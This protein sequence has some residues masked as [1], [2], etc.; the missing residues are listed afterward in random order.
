[1]VEYSG[2]EDGVPLEEVL[3]AD[4]SFADDEGTGSQLWA[5]VG[6]EGRAEGLS[7]CSLESMQLGVN[8]ILRPEFCISTFFVVHE[9]CRVF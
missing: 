7:Y 1:M 8:V 4:F 6:L 9:V 3:D 2:G 5:G